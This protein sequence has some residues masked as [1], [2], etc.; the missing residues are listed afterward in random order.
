MSPPRLPLHTL[1][2]FATVARLQNLR[3]AAEALH[4]T[5]SAVSQQIAGLEERLGFQLFDRRGRR[6]QLNAAGEALLRAVQPALAQLDEGV[7]AATAAALGE[8]QTLRVTMLPSFA[9]RWFLPRLGR[10]HAR[11]PD[12]RIEVDA[13]NRI[14]DLARD[15]FHAGIRTGAGPWPG[16][17]VE[18]LYE[19]PTPFIAVGRP[20]IAH[21]LTQGTPAQLAD[22]PLLG[23][24][25]LWTRWFAAA[26]LRVEPIMLASF[27]DFG[28]LLQA[29]EQGLGLAVAREVMAIDSLREGRLVRLF[30]V[31][32]VHEQAYPYM[33]AFPPAL[34]GWAP[35]QA[36]RAWMKEEFDA[37]L[38]A[39]GRAA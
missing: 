30:D 2:T 34:A 3:A 14:V 15:G 20:D 23:D 19:A 6:V 32:F 39:G 22:E 35:L 10:W 29:A 21:R 28:L 31:S 16:V 1:P 37:A 26:G 38:G 27:N 33:L 7:R 11:H 4:L 13:S 5:H 24:T 12:I 8:S 9:Q 18:R 17:Q 25:E 36:L